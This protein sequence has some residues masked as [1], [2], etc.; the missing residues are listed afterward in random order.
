M[1]C[2]P[3][4]EVFLGGDVPCVHAKDKHN[5]LGA[6]E[7]YEMDEHVFYSC[8]VFENSCGKVENTEQVE[9]LVKLFEEGVLHG[10]C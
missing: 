1:G 5:E 6:A 9:S 3:L 8:E 2:L 4:R 10:G 7:G